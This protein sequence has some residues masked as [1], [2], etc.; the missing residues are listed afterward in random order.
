MVQVFLSH[1][2]SALK[3][4]LTLVSRRIRP[5]DRGP[6]IDG[7][8]FLDLIVDFFVEAGR[9]DGLMVLLHPL[10]GRFGCRLYS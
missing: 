4:C 7:R 5:S 2:P 6:I 1:R 8:Y 3:P 10:D 9:R